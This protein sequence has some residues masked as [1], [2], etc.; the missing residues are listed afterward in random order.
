MTIIKNIRQLKNA[1]VLAERKAASPSLDL[2]RYSLLYG[3]NGAGKSTLSRLFSS[4]QHGSKHERLPANCTFE[5]ELDDGTKFTA[6]KNL[7]G[8][9]KRVC[10]FNQDFI[11]QNL[12]WDA[13][14]ANP[15]FYIGAGQAEAAE[16]LK[17]KEA[18]LPTAKAVRDG[19]VKVVGEREKAF[20]D[21]K[22]LLARDVSE[23][24]RQAA[25]YEAPQLVADFN[26]GATDQD[27]LTEAELD[28]ASTTSQR[29]DAPA[30]VASIEV[31]IEGSVAACRGALDLAPKTMG[32]VVVAE[33]ETYP[34]MVPWVRQG[35]EFHIQNGLTNCLHC[36]EAIP[37]VRR[38]LLASAFDDKLAG[39]IAAV[40]AA[41][42]DA[43]E[44]AHQFDVATA[45][46]PAAAQL[47]AEFQPTFEAAA[48]ALS[49]ALTDVRPLI[50]AA[51]KAL[52]D[53]KSM[54]TT[55]NA[56]A[57]PVL[58]VVEARIAHLAATRDA[59][60][61]I[62]AQ[63]AA[64]VDDF[65]QHQQAARVAIR[66]H[67]VAINKDA[68][69]THQASITEAIA[70]RD[71][72]A[73]VVETLE[74]EIKAL[75]MKVQEHGKAAEKINA[76]VKSY[77]G[78]G[79]LTIAAVEEGYELQR[80]GALVT[81]PPSEGEKTA[82]ALC[83]FLST[84][85]AEDRKLKDLI[86][87]IDDP[88]S[89]LDTRAMN[90]ACSLVRNRVDKAAQIIVL[91]HNQ[92]CLNEFRKHWKSKARATPPTG[93]LLFLDVTV[94]E[95]TKA[96]TSTIIELP[97]QLREYDSEYHFLFQKVLQFEQAG[98]A[99]FDYAFLMPN[100]LRRVLEVFLAFKV[101]RDGN[102]ADKI[103]T[104]CDR[105]KALDQ[106]RLNALERL[107]QVESHSDSLDDLIAQSSMTIEESRDAN[108]ALI[109]LMQTVDPDHL[110]DLRKYCAP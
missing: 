2:K 88:V 19:E 3:F 60:N 30:K 84:L 14:A 22:R 33:L 13:G 23:R 99:Y 44:T 38:E 16:L 37:S 97:K 74:G 20:S 45:A 10:V 90:Y 73:S 92:H 81:G 80:H 39:F 54:P 69:D 49:A 8:L 21:F 89:S 83:Y 59:A 87:V 47:S 63:H 52:R 101:P 102:Y 29:S 53:R 61:A 26:L 12:R 31:P 79:E 46:I 106:D 58:D 67:F 5:I 4:L 51:T 17:T 56:P 55:P 91:T 94:P 11:A 48:L 98:G 66:R 68:F 42:D 34:E 76:L 65:N 62:I 103:A 36:G 15:I 32:G 82:I 7:T 43:S 64:M 100:V 93:R 27:K 107:S 57:L 75:R 9:E 25:R 96:R 71:A 85:E 104:V 78:H 40:N 105:H 77:L 28:A 50:A 110:S 35:H 108:A 6:P 24:L 1:G 41:V 109:Y 95:A 86:V 70:K 18:E 72:A